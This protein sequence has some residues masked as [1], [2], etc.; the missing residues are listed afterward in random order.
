MP[1]KVETMGGQSEATRTR[2]TTLRSDGSTILPGGVPQVRRGRRGVID[3]YDLAIIDLLTVDGRASTKFLAGEVGLTDATVAVRLRSL[4]QRDI[5]RVRAVVDWDVAGLRSPI[6]FFVRVHGRSVRGIAERLMVDP[7]VHSVSEVFGSADLV[8]RVLLADPLEAMAFADETLGTIE[9]VDIV[10]SLLD[11]DVAKHANGFHT[12]GKV[13]GHLPAFPTASTL[14]DPMDSRLLE[15]LVED[16][17]QSLRQIARVLDV[18]EHTV[19][20]RM[21]RLEDTGLIK[22]CA[23]VDQDVSDGTGESAYLALRTQNSSVQPIIDDMVGRAEFRTVDRTVGEYNLL[24]YV[25][26]ASRADFADV[27]DRMRSSPGVERSE[28]WPV[29]SH[30]LCSFPWARL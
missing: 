7:Q 28:T 5:V 9:G 26:A 14:L 22:L 4:M 29:A 16:A 24:S 25:H 23:Q 10:M 19:R 20:A 21:R 13:S 2:G 15:C 6:V 17:R 30:Q 11:V 12:G 3:S 18:S 8:V 1:W 27:I